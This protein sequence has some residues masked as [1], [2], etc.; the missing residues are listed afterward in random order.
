[1]T[2]QEAFDAVCIHAANMDEKSENRDRTACAYRGT[3]GR[4][5]FV[6]AL[7]PDGMYSKSMEGLDV[8]DVLGADFGLW[9]Y[10]ADLSW[11]LLDLQEI[12]DCL[13]V[14]DW[15]REL[16]RAARRHGLSTSVLDSLTFAVNQV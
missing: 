15:R 8:I 10:F 4:K 6:G 12:H 13:C 5:C 11:L 9:E 14:G 3:D 2:K 7:I 16:R 1:M